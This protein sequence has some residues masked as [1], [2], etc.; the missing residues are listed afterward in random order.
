MVYKLGKV[1]LN[2]TVDKDVLTN[3]KKLC[4][5]RD[6]KVSTKINSLMRQWVEENGD[7]IDEA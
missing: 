2:I 5:D 6:I 3:F 1:A 4:N 7:S